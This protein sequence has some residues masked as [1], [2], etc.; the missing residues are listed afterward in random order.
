LLQNG[1]LHF[2]FS[3]SQFSEIVLESLNLHRRETFPEGGL[4]LKK[5][6]RY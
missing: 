3:S 2:V 6:N 4:V 1:I 5:L